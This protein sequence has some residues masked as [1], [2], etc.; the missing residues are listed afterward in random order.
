M[1][2]EDFNIYFKN[3]PD[4]ITSSF[5][6]DS[7]LL[8]KGQESIYTFKFNDIQRSDLLDLF[9]SLSDKTGMDILGFD[10]KLIKIAGHHIADSLLYI[11]ND[12]L[13]NGVFPEDWK[14]ARV[15]PVF[16][17]NGDV[18]AMSNYRPISV[19]G[20]IAKMVEQLV[21]SQLVNYLE[22]HSF[23]TPDQSAYLK[24]HSTQT[25]L[26]RVIDDWLENINENQITGVCLLDISK[27]FDTISHSIL[28]QKLSMYGIKQQELK[29]FSS[30]LDRRKQ[31]VLCHNELSSFVDVTCGV[32]Q[33]SVLGP[34]LFLLFINDMSQFTTD[35]CLTNLYADDSMIYGS[36]DN[37]PEVKQKLQNC[38]QNISSWYKMNRLK[39]N[40]DKTKVMLIGSKAQLKSLNVDDFILS[41]DDTPLELVE[42]AKYLGMFINCDI[43][44]DFHVRRLC[45]TTYYHIS[46]LR[47]LRRIFPKNL[48]LQV[49]KSYIQHRLDYGI[50]LYGSSTQ[51]NIDLVQRV[52]NHA[53][54]L[55]MGNFDYINSRGIDLV[56]SLN[57]Y[58]IR[59]R[60]DYFLSTLMFKAIHGIAPNYLSDRIDM[61]FDIHGYNTREAGSMNVYLPTVHKEMYKNS[62]LYLGGKLWNDLPDFVKNSTNIDTFK[63]NY[64]I[65]KSLT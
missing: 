39:I 43:S 21:R 45:Q 30:Y 20:H 54:R 25:S 63:R 22:E 50:T 37:I 49:Y 12:S 32:P 44:W 26:H 40:I 5:T 15:T 53:A 61:H 55:I 52:Q 7:S 27:C 42:N 10:R 38:I 24:G 17:N 2:A 18:D 60:R 29:W 51:K 64:R 33:G 1:G 3:V 16:K 41:Y 35:G 28:L 56:K 57:L 8:W 31:A 58:T 19:I 36:G 34:F 4:V 6:D 48:I 11:I 9:I 46:L 14:L 65:Y 47:R 62:F 59:E 23:I 13:S